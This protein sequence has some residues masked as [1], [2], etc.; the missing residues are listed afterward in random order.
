[1]DGDMDDY[2]KFVLDRAKAAISKPSQIKEESAAAAPASNN[3]GKKN[4]KK[5]GPSPSTLRHAVK[6]AEER[7][8]QLTS[9]IARID[10]DMANAA[11][12]NPKAL[13]GL[14]RARAK[15]Q[16]DLDAAEA[17]WMTAEEALAEVS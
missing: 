9:E 15:T 17:A 3:K 6:K 16:S 10:D 14:T 11:V 7:M 5:S 2:A 8:A 13:E 12:S 1:Y 4:D